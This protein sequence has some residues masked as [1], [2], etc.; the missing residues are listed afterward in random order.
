MRRTKLP[1]MLER[2]FCDGMTENF[3][4]RLILVAS[5]CIFGSIFR[6]EASEY[7]GCL[8]VEIIGAEDIR[9]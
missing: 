5:M 3:Q 2:F 1:K 7:F 6:L 4:G 9:P 8:T